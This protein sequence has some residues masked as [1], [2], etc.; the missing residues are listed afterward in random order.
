M[1]YFLDTEYDGFGG[2]LISLALYP[3]MAAR[4]FTW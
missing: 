4:S 3:K 2:R 1:R